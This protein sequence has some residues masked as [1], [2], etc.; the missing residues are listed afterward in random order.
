MNWPLLWALLICFGVIIGN[1]MLIKYLDK[2]KFPDTFKDKKST[3]QPSQG[4]DK[5]SKKSS[6]NTS[7]TTNEPKD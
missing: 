2:F 7:K 4:T 5:L 1:L 6:D 3:E